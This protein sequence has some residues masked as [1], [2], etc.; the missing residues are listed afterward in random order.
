MSGWGWPK[1]REFATTWGRWCFSNIIPLKP[2]GHFL[3]IHHHHHNHVGMGGVPLGFGRRVGPQLSSSPPQ[4]LLHLL[5]LALAFPTFVFY[6]LSGYF[7]FWGVSWCCSLTESG[8]CVYWERERD[9]VGLMLVWWYLF[10][11]V[12]LWV[13]MM[14]LRSWGNSIYFTDKTKDTQEKEDK[15]NSQNPINGRM[16][17]SR[18]PLKSHIVICRYKWYFIW[19]HAEKGDE[20]K[21]YTNILYTSAAGRVAIIILCWNVYFVFTKFFN[22]IS[23]ESP[24]IWNLVA[25]NKPKLLFTGSSVVILFYIVFHLWAIIYKDFKISI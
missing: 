3:C 23:R 20:S 18:G 4:C 19:C 2:P 15:N 25:L 12:W 9:I 16:L 11:C 1:I 21:P 17:H 13:E 14:L 5:L 7:N 24:I 22:P 8:F 6:D 10:F